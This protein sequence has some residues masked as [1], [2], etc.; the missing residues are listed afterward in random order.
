VQA[1][2]AVQGRGR[3]GPHAVFDVCR[4]MVDG[5]SSVPCRAAGTVLYVQVVYGTL[6]VCVCVCVCVRG[7]LSV[8][9]KSGGVR[10]TR[11]F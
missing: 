3:R 11:G 7:V 1:A 10:V 6:C 4:Y 2:G 9:K 5:M 8:R